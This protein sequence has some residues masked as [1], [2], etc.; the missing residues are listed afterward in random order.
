MPRPTLRRALA[1]AFAA[2]L[3]PVPARAQAFTPPRGVLSLTLVLQWVENTGH[4]LD[5]GTL[6]RVG[7]S[8][9]AS[10]LL[11]G[12]YAATDRLAITLGLP[13][14]FARYTSDGPSPADL[15]VDTCRCWH[16]SFQDVSLLARYRLGGRALAMTPTLGFVVPSHA[17]AYEG[18]AVVGR[19]LREVQLGVSA[20][21]APPRGALAGFD[22]QA[23]YAYAFV[24][25]PIDVPVDRSF[26]AFS[27]GWSP[28]PSLHVGATASW[29]VTH[30]GL[31]VPADLDTP[32][33]FAQHDRILRD[34]FRRV[35]GDVTW[36]VGRFD[37]FAS[38]TAYVAG[39]NTHDGHAITVGASAYFGGPF[40]W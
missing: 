36:S 2:L 13:Y 20:G 17:Y 5:D 23:S 28:A 30:G 27:L 31:R 37:L 8:A 24:E 35:G 11:E 29:Q 4:R 10:L 38:Y 6:L 18:E 15:P 32:E 39:R 26:G 7:Q 9:D 21:W 16:S 12:T 1:A 14:V 34:D 22:L 3:A 33:H 25:R 19:R 40:G